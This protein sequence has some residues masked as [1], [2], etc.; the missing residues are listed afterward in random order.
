MTIEVN[1]LVRHEDWDR[2]GTVVSV[3]TMDSHSKGYGY[4]SA[5]VDFEHFAGVV[6]GVPIDKLSKVYLRRNS[7]VESG[8]N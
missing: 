5:D 4:C 8:D 1:D 6:Y 7:M 2:V 3:K